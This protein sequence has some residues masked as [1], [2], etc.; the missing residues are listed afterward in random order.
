MQTHVLIFESS[1]LEGLY[2]GDLLYTYIHTY[3]YILFYY[4]LSQDIEYSSL[5]YTVGPCCLIVVVPNSTSVNSKCE[6]SIVK[7][8]V[9]VE[10]IWGLSE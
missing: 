10:E 6:E 5:C 3:I 8:T 7:N 9:R 2:V 4:G 1:Q